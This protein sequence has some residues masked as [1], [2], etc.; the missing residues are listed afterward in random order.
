MCVFVQIFQHLG[1]CLPHTQIQGCFRASAAVMR[2]L[3]LMVSILLIR[4]LASGVTVSHSGDGNCKKKKKKKSVSYIQ[5]IY[6]YKTT[7]LW[8][9]CFC[10]KPGREEITSE[11]FSNFQFQVSD[12]ILVV[13]KIFKGLYQFKNHSGCVLSSQ[14]CYRRTEQMARWWNDP[15]CKLTKIKCH[16]LFCLTLFTI[17]F[18]QFWMMYIC[19]HHRPQPWFVDRGDVDPHPRRE[20]SQPAGCTK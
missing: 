18:F 7:E 6:K 14:W 5:H 10:S 16:F 11:L 8:G 15:M 20:G 4:S 2:L 9:F 13:R 12:V 19:L 3:G 1:V 17:L